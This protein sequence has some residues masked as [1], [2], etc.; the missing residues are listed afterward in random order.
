MRTK[1]LLITLFTSLMSAS[2]QTNVQTYTIETTSGNIQIRLYENTPLH[3]ANFEKLVA[4]QVY[5]SVL[6]HRVIQNFM[7]QGGNPATKNPAYVE[8]ETIPAEFLPEN[9]HKKGA[10][11]AARMGDFVNPEK[12]SSPVQFY[13]VQ[14]K[15]YGD[16]ELQYMESSGGKSWAPEQKEVYKTQGGTPFLDMDYT[17]FGE[18]VS[19][20][21]VVDKI[22]AVPTLP[23]DRPLN[24]VYILRIVKD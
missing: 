24:D 4:E 15:T 16:D 13:I 5:D 6:F 2:C 1:I 22:A 17:V 3:K 7:I 23:G 20:L 21:D 8:G 9:I 18:V 14:G 12:R 10:L 19:G 11:A